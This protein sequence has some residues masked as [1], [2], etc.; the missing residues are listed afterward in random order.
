M[1]V[2][3]FF[4]QDILIL[5]FAFTTGIFLAEN[6]SVHATNYF[7]RLFSQAAK[8]IKGGKQKMLWFIPPLIIGGITVIATAVIITISKLKSFF[9]KSASKTI[10]VKIVRTTIKRHLK[11]DVY[12]ETPEGTLE[13][14]CFDENEKRLGKYS[15]SGKF[16][17]DVANLKKGD[18]L[19]V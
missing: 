17:Q 4:L 15:I 11:N 16:S 18:Y 14:I 7:F 12:N 9:K 13:A 6:P 2:F 3:F 1:T 5:S 10:W 8:K 19:Y